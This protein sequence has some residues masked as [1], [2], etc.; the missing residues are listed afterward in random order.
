MVLLA[1]DALAPKNPTKEEQ[2]IYRLLPS[3]KRPLSTFSPQSLCLWLC[4][5][6]RRRGATQ[7]YE[8]VVW[9]E[10]GLPAAEAG[11]RLSRQLKEKSKVT[12]A[13]ADIPL[14]LP[15]SLRSNKSVKEEKNSF[16]MLFMFFFFPS[17]RFMSLANV[18]TV[19]NSVSA[20]FYLRWEWIEGSNS[21][22]LCDNSSVTKVK[23]FSSM[24]QKE[25][26]NHEFQFGNKKA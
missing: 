24:K 19:E 7:C 13:S 18:Q 6:C 5:W 1:L 12:A 9:E 25:T 21:L 10:E 2:S 14:K 15:F 4:F 20:Y 26:K 3:Q 17:M 22:C 8:D 11:H 16:L 23:V